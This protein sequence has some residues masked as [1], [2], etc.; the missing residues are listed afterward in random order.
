MANSNIAARSADGLDGGDLAALR[1]P[2]DLTGLALLAGLAG[3]DG[4]VS[5]SM[6]AALTSESFLM[7]ICGWT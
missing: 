7:P 5:R 1:M 4:P 3:D 6:S 2:A